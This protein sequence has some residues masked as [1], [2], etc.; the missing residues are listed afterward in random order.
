M[1]TFQWGKEL[2]V[3]ERVRERE[4]EREQGYSCV[5]SGTPL[6]VT[7]VGQNKVSIQ[8]REAALMFLGKEEVHSGVSL[9]RIPQ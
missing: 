8:E 4:R 7:P 3:R 2:R 5:Y 1:N 9:E 6:I